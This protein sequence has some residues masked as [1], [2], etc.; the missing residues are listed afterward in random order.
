[1]I[2]QPDL[3]HGI[4]R[5]YRLSSHISIAPSMSRRRSE[6]GGSCIAIRLIDMP[7]SRLWII[8]IW[9][10]FVPGA[11]LRRIPKKR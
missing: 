7:T 10:R 11:C 8:G 1:M 9:A 6:M 5:R 2:A 4:S 3:C